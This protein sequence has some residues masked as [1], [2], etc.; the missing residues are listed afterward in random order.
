M[1]Q[2]LGLDIATTAA[3]AIVV[4]EGGRVLSSAAVSYP[5]CSPKPLW[6]E[7][8]PEDWWRAI[9]TCIGKALAG[10]GLSGAEIAAVGV[11]GQMHTLVALDGAGAVIRPAILWNDQRAGPQ[12][13]AITRRVGSLE[14]AVD[15]T[16]NAVLPG[17]TAPKL[18]WMEQYEPG[19][20]RCLRHI[21][22][23]KDFV[24]LRLTG[25]F[26][27][28]VSDASGTALFD[29]G[30]R[31]WSRPMVELLEVSFDWLPECYE[32]VQTVGCVSRS[33]AEATGLR[34]GTPVVAGAGDQAA[35][36]IGCGATRPGIVVVTTGTSGV[37]F[38]ATDRFTPDA[39]GRAHAFCHAAPG[40]WHVMGVM[41]SAGG[42]L[43]WFRDA[44]GAFDQAG[45]RLSGDDAYSG[46]SED[47]SAVP[48]GSEGLLF[49]PYLAGERCP[50]PDPL[51][52]GAFIGLTSRHGR[53][54]MVRAIMEG[55]A[56]GLRDCI[57]LI[58]R[59]D[60]PI[61]Q[62]RCSGGGSKS[63]VWRRIQAS[64][65]ERELSIV[66][67]P[68]GAAFGVAL[69]AAVAAGMFGSVD[70]AAHLTVHE[71]GVVK[72]DVDAARTYEREYVMYKE[73][74]GMLTP[75]FGSIASLQ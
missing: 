18:L 57:E 50:H 74:Y 51:A 66:D 32:S 8:D 43:R 16:G 62:V 17:F 28:D 61:V 30:A 42:S 3:K 29:V 48:A 25:E 71:M 64:A 15:L 45:T 5:I 67:N 46:L 70:E 31:R 33:A 27:T 22:L 24:R 7:Q 2:V 65:F 69:L 75:L 44:L 36:A 9:I 1:S 34:L 73:A 72:P 35:Q 38:A 68:E 23:P 56:F 13:E 55:V 12:C 21:L 63:D 20:Y 58:S 47:A 54:H 52:R 10:A 49:L 11:T 26:A 39:M 6:S 40:R 4:D 53:G 60:V 37:V 19:L 59:L 41:L 14:R